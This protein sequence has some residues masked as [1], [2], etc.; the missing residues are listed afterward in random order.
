MLKNTRKLFAAIVIL[1]MAISVFQIG[2]VFADTTTQ[3]LPF[4][5]NWTSA[6][7][8]TAAD[9]WSGVPG[10]T[11]Y[12]G[13]NLTAVTGVDPQTVL[14]ESATAG[15]LTVLANQTSTGITNGDVAEFEITDPTIALQGS[16]TADA[17]YILIAVNTTALS[18]INIS[19][20]LRDIDGSA[21]NA[22]QAVALQ[23]RVGSSGSFTNVPTGY[24]ADATSGPSLATLVTPVS[25]TLPAA[26]DNQPLVQIRIITTNAAGNDEWVGVDDISITGGVV[27]GTT[28]SINDVA[29]SEGN[30]G[31]T[32]F[33]FTV[34]LSDPAPAGGVTFDIA[35]EDNSATTADNDYTVSSL[36]GES[37]PEGSDTYNFTVSVNGDSAAES[38]ET[39]YVNVTNVTGTDVTV[40]DV[41]G[42]GTINNDDIVITAISTIQGSGS[43]SPLV[44]TVV[45]TQGIVVSD[46]E[47]ASPALRGFYIQSEVGDGDPAT[48]DGLFVFNG[49][50]NNVANGDLVQ[51]TGTVSEF[52][53][54]TQLDTVT[55]IVVLG[56]GSVTATDV[57]LPFASA[58]EPEQYEGMLVR[59]PQT[60]FVTEIY[61]LGRFGQV[62]LSG[63]DRLFQ[64]T[65]IVLPG[66]PA[67]AQQATNNLN[68]IVL[69]DSSQAQNP[70][71]ILFGRGGSPLSA[72][73]TLRGG[74]TVTDLLGVFTYTW[75]GDS[76]SPNAY[77]IRPVNALGGGIPNFVAANPRPSTPEAV[78]GSIK[79]TGMNV[80]NYFNT[81]GNGNC[82]T[83]VGGS[84]TDC[85]G[86]TDATEFTR[87]SDKI[88]NAILAIDPDVI[89][90]VEIENDGYGASSAIQDLVNKLNAIAGPGAYAFIDADANT[91]IVNVLGADAIKVGL[92]YQPA[93]VTPIGATA[94]LDT[95]AFVNGGDSAARNRVS[96]LQAFQ[97]NATDEIF[98]ANVNHL[99]SK[100]SACDTPD[101][102]DGQGNCAAVRTNAANTLAAWIATDPTG[103]G[104]PDV[105]ILGD[106][107]SYAM[108]DP[109]AALET[110]G[111]TNL[112][113][114]FGN[115]VYSY[116]FDGQWG[117]LDYAMA[118]SSL[119][120]QVSGVTEFHINSD[121]PIVLDYNTEFKTA[122]QIVSLYSSDPFRTSDHDPIIVGLNLD[123]TLPV[124][125][126]PGDMT[127]EAASAA[128][129]VVN[130]TASA[131][132]N[133]DG[134]LPVTC[135][136]ASGT[137]FPL[138]E[139]NVDCSATDNAGNTGHGY[140]KITVEDTTAPTLDLPADMS[141]P[142]TGPSGAVVNYTVTANDAV[143][144]SP[145][146]DCL[147]TSGSTFALGT[148][149]VNCTATDDATNS[150]NGS[151]DITVTAANNSPTDIALTNSA[152]DENQ[153]IATVVGTLSTT[154]ADL[155]DTHT[156]SFCGGTDDASFQISGSDLQTNAIFDYET[157]NAYSICV[158]TDDGNGGTFDETFPITVNNLV[159]TATATFKSFG[160][161]DGWTLE[162]GE[163]T[164]LGGSINFGRVT[165]RL[166]DTS[167][168][169]QYRS[170]LSFDTSSLPD[171][172]VITKVT[173]KLMQEKVV[174]GGDPV[175][176]FQGFLIDIRKGTIGT[177]ALQALDFQA[178]TNATYGPF[179]TA[180]IAN[181]FSFDM[182]TAKLYVNRMAT[183]SGLTQFRLRFQLDDDNNALA[184][185]LTLYSGNAGP[186]RRPQLI[187]EYHL[188]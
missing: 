178:A 137:I 30:S 82:T 71:P 52:Q 151:F 159:E 28:L 16:G 27:P 101:S 51:V 12:L 69:D 99:K 33:T 56:S 129:A 23:Y 121:E 119:L 176:A 177:S 175:S 92:L 169:M 174:G 132:D 90:I 29:L 89:G 54:Q 140:F 17:P 55:S 59:F 98:I 106:L 107:N 25:V 124:V 184:N 144:A 18:S 154:D 96:L 163:N 84:S 187:I 53:D 83:G 155:G 1:A 147:P 46:D 50:N 143:D 3:T 183:G 109:I 43:A 167:S 42:L 139:T 150:S 118:N 47:G 138:G 120:A 61:Q 97:V 20:N 9:D 114:H 161:L 104:D 123:A 133:V 157:K 40:T 79:V 108:E 63:N 5:Q 88:V 62:T 102:G 142:A 72:S 66:A 126:V 70:D 170:I 164:N 145:L 173:L 78:G 22:I 4:S 85:R 31:T 21:D 35:T 128:G 130:Y 149:T 11:G 179:I 122:G 182:T 158:R 39:F 111:Y 112:G 100:G 110:A 65:N 49:N 81:F 117:T 48:S 136:P 168:R 38:N 166:G 103:V 87:Q 91:G 95:V 134:A 131:D 2:S 186:L 165:L 171:N 113:E 37:I 68:K 15:D 180:P 26:V 148:T 13:Q 185:Y 105:I 57:N 6:S 32:D 67:I 41:Q 135:S 45:T 74:D 188:P 7:L 60:L 34:T 36:P 172:A 115:D 146:V 19:Y 125:T 86:A 73:N 64:P 24:V 127:K 75:G 94:A 141:V 152:V 80:L 8:I 181:W 44:G 160:P 156:Y 116:V 76:A 77:R 153:P 14:G 162:S 10:I 58:S 93:A